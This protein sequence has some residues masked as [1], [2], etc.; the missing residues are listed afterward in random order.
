M[1]PRKAMDFSSINFYGEIK[2]LKQIYSALSIEINDFFLEL[3]EFPAEK[4]VC[5]QH[6][7]TD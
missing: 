7:L 3:S 5:Y 4:P 1:N 6:T 2:A